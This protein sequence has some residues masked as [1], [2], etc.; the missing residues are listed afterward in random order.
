MGNIEKVLFGKALT[1]LLIILF[2]S[3]VGC[4]EVKEGPTKTYYKSGK[5]KTVI[6]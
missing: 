3:S 5:L 1:V 4:S 2:G 6:N